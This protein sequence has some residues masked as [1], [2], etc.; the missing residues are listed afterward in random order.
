MRKWWLIVG[1]LFL[2]VGCALQPP[3]PINEDEKTELAIKSLSFDS[4]GSMYQLI[5]PF[6]ESKVRLEHEARGI[7]REDT[8]EITKQ[9]L[10][11]SKLYFD[12]KAYYIAEG[13]VLQGEHYTNVLRFNSEN[14]P[15]GLNPAKDEVFTSMS[16]KELV[17][18]VLLYDIFEIDFYKEASLE[19]DLAGISLA[20]VLNSNITQE[21][22]S[23]EKIKPEQLMTYGE[24]AAR[25]LMSY[26]RSQPNMNLV[27][28]FITLY[29]LEK[30]DSNVP[31]AMMA[32]GYFEGNS[33]Q[34]TKIDGK[35]FIV[36][37]TGAYNAAPA[38]ASEYSIFYEQLK[39]FLPSEQIGTVGF[40]Y[41]EDGIL[42]KLHV[43]IHSSGK[44]YLE[45][46]G[47][48]QYG[49]ALLKQ[50]FEATEFD[51]LLEVKINGKTQMV[52]ERKN[53]QL[54]V[55]EW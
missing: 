45:T 42:K 51:I 24:N 40:I 9:L 12:S 49:I 19:S 2:L 53:G 34:F 31:G 26:L 55:I 50:R 41:V 39:D 30:Q 25:K 32:H 43:V 47:V 46:L 11:F 38:F 54:K 21:D 27:P 44:T 29:S 1:L 17:Q 10:K 37:S 4:D 48:G 5:V 6:N 18:P 52:M 28:I 13:S 8:F 36:P 14:V 35:W 7:Y 16:G 15:E 20:L 3:E 33:G 23:V 22:G